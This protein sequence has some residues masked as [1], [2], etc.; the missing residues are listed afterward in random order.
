MDDETEF[1]T[2]FRPTRVVV[3][4]TGSPSSGAALRR[5]VQEARRTGRGLVPVLAWEPPG[6]EAVYRLAPE[7]ALAAIWQHQ[8]RQCLETAVNEALGALPQDV[9]VELA[10][11]R[12]PA[13]YALTA[14]ADQPEDLLVLGAGPRRPLLRRLRGRVR[15]RATAHAKAPVLLVS[16]QGLPGLPGRPG[17]MRRE[18][19]HVTA[20][21]F[22][23]RPP[24]LEYRCSPPD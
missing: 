8:A 14:L 1:S 7:P 13:W 23:S 18:P 21:D 15:R 4:V 22:L 5:A 19:R 17:R 16:H 9:P 3:G 6:G 11:V 2:G 10:V 12:G 20:E 24:R